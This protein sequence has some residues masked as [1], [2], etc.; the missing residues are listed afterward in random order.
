MKKLVLLSVLVISLCG[1]NP[2]NRIP[3][4]L[5]ND[6]LSTSEARLQYESDLKIQKTIKQ[7]ETILKFKQKNKGFYNQFTN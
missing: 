3:H 1:C 6:N 4:N 5:N 2:S 7:H